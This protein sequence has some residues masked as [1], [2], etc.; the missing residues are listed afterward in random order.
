MSGGDP[1]PVVSAAHERIL[2]VPFFSGSADDAVKYIRQIG[3]LVVIPAAPALL[4]L[5]YD[6]DYRLAL[7]KADVVL[8]D[9]GLLTR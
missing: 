2:G 8:A 7:Q 1:I 5:R 4:K 6:E 9:S 3:G